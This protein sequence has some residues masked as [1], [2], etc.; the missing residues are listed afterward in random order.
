MANTF[1]KIASVTVGSGGASSI[2]FTSIPATYTDLCVLLSGR[3]SGNFGG[4]DSMSDYAYLRFNSSSSNYSARVLYGYGG[5]VGSSNNSAQSSL[6]GFYIDGSGATASTFGNTLIYVP[7]YA[8]SNY[9]SVSAD[10]VSEHNGTTAYMN[11][12]AGLWSNTSAITGIS[13]TIANGN[14]VQY[15]TAVLYGI[16]NS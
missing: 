10:S 16:S 3:S 9:K 12:L 6:I 2:D 4:N 14:Y 15:S 7:N 13:F 1:T 5:G 8:G 11:L